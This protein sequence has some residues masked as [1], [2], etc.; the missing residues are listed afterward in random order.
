[1]PCDPIPPGECGH[2]EAVWVPAAI[3]HKDAYKFTSPP[4][5]LVCRACRLYL[6]RMAARAG[7]PLIVAPDCSY[8]R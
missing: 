2:P 4:C 8:L 6:G 1:M 7:D 3:D 5:A